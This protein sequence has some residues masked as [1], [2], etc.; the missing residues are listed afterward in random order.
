MKKVIITGATGFI[1]GS[2]S[3]KLMSQGITV[4]GVDIN[5]EKLDDMK[6]F[7]N[8]V[9]IVADFSKYNE[10]DQLIDAY[11]FDC[12]FHVAWAGSLGGA[13]LYNHTLQ[14]YN[15]EAACIACDKAVS[16]HVKRFVFCSS[17]YSEMFSTESDHP[18]N[19][20]G[21][22][23]K[24]AAALC[25]AICNKN[26]IECNIAVLTNTYG[27][28]DTSN[29]AVNTF[30]RKMLKNEKLD[31]VAGD[32]AND[33]VY[34]DDTVTGISAVASSP[35]SFKTYYVGHSNISTFKS[36][37]IEMKKVL[38]SSSELAFGT[39]SDNTFVDYS[40]FNSNE[41]YEDTAFKCIVDFKESIIK[42]AEWIKSLNWEE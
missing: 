40:V 27:Y 19:Y 36:K 30:V 5:A 38:N 28:G 29:K 34:I 32:R 15:V 11:D 37:L 14:N 22:A 18:I 4:Y 33:W 16:L 20:Y 13:D 12:F 42:T 9:P 41:L 35:C 21:I 26:G 39:F 8:F 10:L 17:S 7:G 6:R 3:K 2:L 31:L 1:G 25:M 23:K 24:S